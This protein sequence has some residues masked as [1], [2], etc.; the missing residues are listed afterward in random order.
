[1]SGFEFQLTETKNNHEITRNELTDTQN[2]L[3][4]TRN[5]LTSTQN[6]LEITRNELTGTQNDLEITRNELT[7]IQNDLQ[8]T[9]NELTDIQN[10]LTRFQNDHKITKNKLKEIEGALKTGQIV[11]NFEKDLATYIYPHGKRIGSRKI[12]TNMKKWLEEKKNTPQ[13]QEANVKWNALKREFSWT[14]EHE[15]VFFKL[16]ECRIEFAHPSRDRVA[17]HLG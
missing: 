10:E 9:R 1:M 17:A 7:G 13:G 15:R 16:L 8:I 4:I 3:E 2:D 14:S 5:E 11:F 12:F 6:D